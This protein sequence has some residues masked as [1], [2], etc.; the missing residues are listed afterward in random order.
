MRLPASVR[1]RNVR[2]IIVVALAI[3]AMPWHSSRAADWEPPPPMPDEFDWLQLNSGEWLKGEIK[4]LYQDSLEFDSEELDVLTLDL[5]DIKMIRS[6]QIINMRSRNGQTAIGKLL[7]DGDTVVVLGDTEQTTFVRADI[8]TVTAGVPRERNFWVGNVTVG[9][10]FRS[11]NTEQVE[12]STRLNFQR[13]T[14]ISRV[15]IDHL[16]N[17][18]RTHGVTTAENQRGSFKWDRFRNEKLFVTP[19]FSEYFSDPFQNI[20]RRY[21]F[22]TAAGYQLRDS[23]K[24]DWSV[25]VGPAYQE[26]QYDQ[27]E[28]GVADTEGTWALSAGSVYDINLTSR[29]EF[30]A[31]YRFQLTSEDAGRYNHHFIG[32]FQFE[33]T[34]AL[35][36]DLSLVWDKIKLPKPNADGTIPQSDDYRFIV[37]IGYEF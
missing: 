2:H 9:G 7:L 26:T 28:V 27:V 15:V 33:L 24:T 18:T 11:G 12:A 32:A 22:G 10:N 6:A 29:V 21:T 3:A 25:S 36:I 35:D 5:E 23:S 1:I 8:L 13:R 34:N 31:D 16:G 17:Y 37:G 30:S 19:L 14:I 20:A 4:V